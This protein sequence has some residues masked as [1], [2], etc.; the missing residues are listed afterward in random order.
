MLSNSHIE[1]LIS[2]GVFNKR[3]GI[4]SNLSRN[5]DKFEPIYQYVVQHT[6]FLPSASFTERVY[7][8]KNNITEKPCCKY[9]GNVVNSWNQTNGYALFCSKVCT[10]KLNIDN[11][12][13][14]NMELYEVKYIFQTPDFKA[15]QILA[16]QIKYGVDYIS[17]VPAYQQR[18]KENNMIKF[19]VE[20]T[21]KLQIVQEK[22]NHTM[23]QRYGG[24]CS[25]VI[26]ELN[27]KRKQTMISVHGVEHALQS[28][29]CLE[30]RAHT[31]IARYGENSPAKC[32]DLIEKTKDT[33]NI[34]YGADF[35]SQH[36]MI[37]NGS[38]ERLQDIEYMQYEH[39]VLLKSVSIL[40]E[41]LEVVPIT[42]Q[43][44][45]KQHNI[46]EVSYSGSCGQSKLTEFI[47]LHP[48]TTVINSKVLGKKEIDVY[49]PELKIGF[50][51]NGLYWHSELSGMDSNYHLDK[52][53]LCNKSGISLYQIWSCEWEQKQDIVKSYIND[54][55]KLNNPIY[56]N[57]YVIHLLSINESEIFFNTNHIYGY[58]YANISY[59]L[60]LDNELVYALSMNDNLIIQHTNIL[61]N[62]IINGLNTLLLY[63]IQQHEFNTIIAHTDNRWDHGILYEQ[64][65]FVHT[66]N[67]SPSYYYFNLNKN[68][69]LISKREIDKL[70][71]I[72]DTNNTE[73]E[74]MKNNGYNRVWDCGDTTWELKI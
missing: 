74:N 67:N 64:L 8:L 22:R 2:K 66:N 13:Q 57:D 43:R 6:L 15:S 24:D 47:S 71:L 7:C 14:K 73:W 69:Y 59:G 33:N 27:E 56:S 3:M 23:I 26:P 18:K 10:L 20:H 40:A 29:S 17:Q 37:S 48:Y 61:N 70:D 31:M 58:Q 21:S 41:Q 60:F 28:Q 39:H 4:N 34:R 16:N 11:I 1:Y 25:F 42:V 49:L 45:L 50:E 53:T 55:L 72:W 12:K 52:L 63:I 62:N 68:K 5:K 44:Y 30:K 54:I 36:H 35:Y 9:C 65:G 46:E 19:G 32:A 38:L 51:Y